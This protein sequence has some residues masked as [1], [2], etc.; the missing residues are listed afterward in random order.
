MGGQCGNQNS[1]VFRGAGSAGSFF[2]QK[3]EV[4]YGVSGFVCQLDT[5]YGMGIAFQHRSVMVAA[6]SPEMEHTG[7]QTTHQLEHGQRMESE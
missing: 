5:E 4:H 3:V 6:S 7:W 1:V 2:S